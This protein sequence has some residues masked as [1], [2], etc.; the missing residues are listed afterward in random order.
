MFVDM[1]GFADMTEAHDFDSDHDDTLSTGVFFASALTRQF[2][3]FH[4]CLNQSDWQSRVT[5]GITFSDSGFFVFESPYDALHASSQLMRSLVLAGVACRMGLGSGSFRAISFGTTTALRTSRVRHSSQFLG[6]GVV[7]V[8]KAESSGLAGMRIRIHDSAAEI[9]AK[10]FSDMVVPVQETLPTSSKVRWEG[11][12]LF[13]KIQMRQKF[14]VLGR[15]LL[16]GFPLENKNDLLVM[17]VAAMMTE[18]PPKAAHHY[19]AT[20]QS[21]EVMKLTLTTTHWRPT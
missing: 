19:Q 14:S 21:L 8:F 1:L 5:T 10:R 16:A 4:E 9:L 6:T 12:Y 13:D 3:R 15:T 7:R 20:L 2:G 18:A 17:A 11:N